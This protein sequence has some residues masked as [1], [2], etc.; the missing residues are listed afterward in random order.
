MNEHS[1]FCFAYLQRHAGDLTL[2]ENPREEDNDTDNVPVYAGPERRRSRRRA[3]N[4][5]HAG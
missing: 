5:T 3:A 4:D 2:K 1:Q